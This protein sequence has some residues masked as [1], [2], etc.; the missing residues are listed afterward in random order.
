MNILA[1]FEFTTTIRAGFIWSA[2]DVLSVPTHAAISADITTFYI[3][4]FWADGC[5][6]MCNIGHFRTSTF[7]IYPI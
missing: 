7:V 2:V 4:Q 3:I 5:F 6:Y 1:E